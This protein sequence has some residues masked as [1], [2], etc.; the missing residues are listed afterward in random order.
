MHQLCLL[1]SLRVTNGAAVR[2]GFCCPFKQFLEPL[3]QQVEPF[4]SSFGTWTISDLNKVKMCRAILVLQYTCM[5]F[6]SLSL[7][8]FSERNQKGKTLCCP[9]V[10]REISFSLDTVTNFLS[11]HFSQ[12]GQFALR[13]QLAILPERVTPHRFDCIAS[14]LLPGQATNMTPPPPPG[15][16]ASVHHGQRQGLNVGCRLKFHYFV[17]CW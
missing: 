12:K 6:R 1:Q 17:C 13:G 10:L 9:F 16:I 5:T 15:A 8:P 3:L 2:H 11:K 4:F 7:S 14:R